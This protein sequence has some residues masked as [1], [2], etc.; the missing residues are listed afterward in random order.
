[1]MECDKSDKVLEIGI[2]TGSSFQYYP[3]ET[4]VIG[5]DISPDML[6]LA[7]KKIKKNQYN[8]KYISMMNGEYLSFADNTFDKVVAMYVISVTENP[9]KL[10]QEMKRVCKDD[11]DIFIVNHFSSDN[12]SVLCKIFEKSLMPVSRILGWKPYFPFKDFNNYANLNIKEVTKTNL[13]DY[14]D[15]IHATNSK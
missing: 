10:I 14:W 12:D 11:G 3:R 7:T 6:K 1:M 4:N 15:I 8:N 13:F 9:K 2:G 5:V